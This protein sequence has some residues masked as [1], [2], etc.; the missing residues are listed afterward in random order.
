MS[1][2][3]TPEET[4][5]KIDTTLDELDRLLADLPIPVNVQN[6]LRNTVYAIFEE[7]EQALEEA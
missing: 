5:E 1:K 4:L 3:T 6:R 7:I 2:L